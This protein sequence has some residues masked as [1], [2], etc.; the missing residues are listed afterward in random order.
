MR[1]IAFLSAVSNTSMPGLRVDV[2]ASVSA[3]Y[4]MP[5]AVARLPLRITLLLNCWSVWLP[6]LRSGERRRSVG[7]ALRGIWL[8]GL[9]LGIRVLRPVERSA[10]LAV[11]HARCVERAADDVVLD[12]RQVGNAAAAH[13]HH[14]VLLEI[15][16]D[17]RDVRG[18]FHLIGEADSSDLPQGGVRLLRGHRADDR[19]GA[20]L[21]GRAAAQLDVAALERVPRRAEGGRVYFLALRLASLAYELRDRWHRYSFYRWLRARTSAP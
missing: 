8:S 14:G 1:G 16:A 7:R 9:L 6:Y 19:A 5:S 15:V 3:P 12:R 18:D 13:E 10:L 11:L 17:A 21:L 2:S 4:T 20:T